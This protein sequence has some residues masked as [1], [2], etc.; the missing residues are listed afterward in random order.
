[1]TTLISLP[2]SSTYTLV[3]DLSESAALANVHRAAPDEWVREEL[4]LA[5]LGPR[6]WGRV[7]HFRNY[8][9][10]G[11]GESAGQV[12]SPKALGAFFQFVD[13]FTFPS[14]VVPSV[15]LTDRGGIELCWEDEGRKSVQVEFTR[16]G[17]EFYREATGEEGMV[18]HGALQQHLLRLAS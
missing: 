12:L 8:Y 1:M 15:F 6:G 2:R 4:L 10:S 7:H 18:T 17:A 13:A 11:W 5:K 3:N 9:T 14:G 16:T